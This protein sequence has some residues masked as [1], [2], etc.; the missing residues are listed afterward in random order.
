MP[1]RTCRELD[2]GPRRCAWC[3]PCSQSLGPGRGLTLSLETE[4]PESDP[5]RRY[6]LL[7]G[8]YGYRRRSAPRS[9]RV[10]HGIPS[11]ASPSPRDLVSIDCGAVLWRLQ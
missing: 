2:A 11:A 8:L 5:K 6:P 3:Y 10:V 1:Q 9:D 4:M 7:P